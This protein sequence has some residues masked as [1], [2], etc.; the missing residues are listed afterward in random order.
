MLFR[1]SFCANCGERIER[2]EWGL[3]TSRRFCAVC[4][5]EF[6]GQDYIPRVFVVFG[7]LAF[8]FGFGGYLRSGSNVSESRIARQTKRSVEVPPTDPQPQLKE[9]PPEQQNANTA[10]VNAQPRSLVSA[11]AP[12]T[13]TDLQPIRRPV[14]VV[15]DAYICGAETKKGTPCSRRVKGNIRCYQHLGMPAMLS[16]DKLKINTNIR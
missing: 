4:E 11:P 1:P 13:Q 16:P 5:S 2:S 15:D 10:A 9:R 12:A 7:L 14:S 8:V 6:K 3:L